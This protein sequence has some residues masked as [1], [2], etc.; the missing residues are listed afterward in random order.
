MKYEIESK[1]TRSYY[2]NTVIN[3]RWIVN[4]VLFI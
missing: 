2:T 3:L 4:G 1:N